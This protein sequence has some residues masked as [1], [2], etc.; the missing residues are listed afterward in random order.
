MENKKVENLEKKVAEN[1]EVGSPASSAP[2][3]KWIG[4]VHENFDLVNSKSRTEGGYPTGEAPTQR[5]DPDTP[6]FRD[7][8]ITQLSP[9]RND[10]L[11]GHVDKKAKL[12]EP[13]SPAHIVSGS[14]SGG[15]GSSGGDPYGLYL[16]QT[17]AAATQ[18]KGPMPPAA[19]QAAAMQ[20]WSNHYAQAVKVI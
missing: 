4:H 20:A 12:E 13:F 15:N 11:R 1:Q 10:H 2:P 17:W 14:G 6:I 16:Y 5:V 9:T 7:P 19:M 3:G 18:G 8:R